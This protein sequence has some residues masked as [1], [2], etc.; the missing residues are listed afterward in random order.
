MQIASLHQLN[1]EQTHPR[2]VSSLTTELPK[3][4]EIEHKFIDG[5]VEV[6]ML[7]AVQHTQFI[8]IQV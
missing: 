1:Q 5:I 3:V 2:E 6:A 8:R 7:F 4:E